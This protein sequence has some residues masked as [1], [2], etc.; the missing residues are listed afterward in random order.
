MSGLIGLEEMFMVAV[1]QLFASCRWRTEGIK[2]PGS[3]LELYR[4]LIG[5]RIVITEKSC[6]DRDYWKKTTGIGIGTG[7]AGK[8]T[9][10][11]RPGPEIWQIHRNYDRD[12]SKKELPGPDRDRAQKNLVPHIS[13]LYLYTYGLIP[14]PLYLSLISIPLY[15]SPYIYT[16]TPIPY[17]YPLID[18]NLN[19]VKVS[20][21]F[22]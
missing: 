12:C 6:R 11:F 16:L 21:V 4:N 2:F 20:I 14:I 22:K 3:Q 15:L 18:V 9:T 10:R 5:S 7:T 1:A 8:I 19:R 17:T 13:N